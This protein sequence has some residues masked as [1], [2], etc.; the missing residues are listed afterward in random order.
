MASIMQHAVMN[1]SIPQPLFV[2]TIEG[3]PACTSDTETQDISAKFIVMVLLQGAQHFIV[4]D[5]PFRIDA[6]FGE[7]CAPFVFVLNVARA[8]KLTFINASKVPLRKVMISA[9]LSWMNWLISAQ[10]DG[11]P[12]LKEFLSTHLAHFRIDASR[13]ILGLAEQLMNPPVGMQGE[14][15]TLFRSSRAFDL[16]SLTCVD[17]AAHKVERQ[18]P[19]LS[20]ARQSERVYNYILANLGE[21]L[22]IETIARECGGSVSSIQRHFKEHYGVTVF[23]FIRRSRLELAY[24][25]LERE[26]ATIGQA[27]HLAGYNTPSNFTTAFKK[28]YGVSPKYKRR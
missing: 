8:S 5:V 11:V 23:E 21:E 16:M 7:T 19:H 12:A 13:H 9:P 20:S 17:L 24:D 22:T 3:V 4:D 1:L 25:A 18:S 15:R 27:A 26:G 6:G 14:M 2:G 28:T 10:S